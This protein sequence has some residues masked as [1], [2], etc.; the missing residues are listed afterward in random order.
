MSTG[1][2][3]SDKDVLAGFDFVFALHN[4]STGPLS[5]TA[6]A[7][8]LAATGAV[9]DALAGTASQAD[10]TALDARVAANES[11]VSGNGIDRDPV[12]A[13]AGS[14]ITLSGSQTVDGVTLSNGDR[15]GAG[16]QTAPEEI[17][18]YIYN[19]SGPWM[20]ASDMDASS[21][22]NLSTVFVSG[23]TTYGGH[24]YRF[25]V[26]D[27]DTFA[28][29]TDAITATQVG[30]AGALGDQLAL[31]A[32]ADDPTF[33]G[34][35]DMSGAD[36]V[37]V[38]DGAV[39]GHAVNKGQLDA[40]VENI[41]AL[42]KLTTT[43][44]RAAGEVAASSS[45]SAATVVL[46]APVPVDGQ[47]TTIRLDS[48]ASGTFSIR[49]FDRDG[50]DFTQS[51]SDTDVSI[52]GGGTNTITLETPISVTAGQYLGGYF[53]ATGVL[54]FDNGANDNPYFLA[55]GDQTSFTDSLA[56]N[57]LELGFD[58]Q[59][60]VL[61]V[62]N[63]Q[64]VQSGASVQDAVAETRDVVIGFP[65]TLVE[66]VNTN[67]YWRVFD[68]P[69]PADG[70]VTELEWY[71]TQGYLIAG[72]WER[73]GDTW[74]KVSSQNVYGTGTGVVSADLA[75]PIRKGQYLGLL[76]SD[77]GQA[78]RRLA[79]QTTVGTVVFSADTSGDLS[80]FA[81]TDPNLAEHIQARFTLKVRDLARAV[82][83]DN[84]ARIIVFGDSYT[85]SDYTLPGKAWISI[86]SEQ[87]DFMWENHSTSGHTMSNRLSNIGSST[88]GDIP[89]LAHAEVTYLMSYIGENDDNSLS[90]AAFTEDME[91]FCQAARGIGAV[92]LLV[93]QHTD[94]YGG[95]AVAIFKDLADRYGG[96]YGS[97]RGN[98]YEADVDANREA[99]FQSGGHYGTRKAHVISD[100][101]TRIVNSLPRPQQALKVFRPRS[102]VTVST[103]ADLAFVNR[104]A[105]R[106]LW[107]EIKPGQSGLKAV[108]YAEYDEVD[109]ITPGTDSEITPSEYMS[110]IDGAGVSC[111]DYALIEVL[112][113]S[114]R[115]EASW[116]EMGDVDA[117]LYFYDGQA[118]AWVEI[119]SDG[120][121]AWLLPRYVMRRGLMGDRLPLLIEKSGSF[122]LTD[123]VFRWIGDAVSVTHAPRLSLARPSGSELLA[124]TL[125]GTALELADW[126]VT[127]T[128]TAEGSP[129]EAP[130]G[131]TSYCTVTDA[132][133]IA[134]TVTVPDSGLEREVEIRVRGRFL[135]AIFDSS[136]DTFPDDS[137]ITLDSYDERDLVITATV[138]SN[139]I[140][141]TRPVGLSWRD[142]RVRIPV[143]AG[144]S[145]LTVEI[146]TAGASI[147][148]AEVSV[149][150]VS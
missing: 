77:S 119:E 51:G 22:I 2:R 124:Q 91:E 121:G 105:R 63:M 31:K 38:P 149:R 27:P 62:A 125:C 117:A 133:T 86:A 106:A 35:V 115:I 140:P 70:I 100:E 111:E 138:N 8:A 34:D 10:L 23:G 88:Y 57:T 56:S 116:F 72:I 75:I 128:V 9:A 120:S 146:A 98:A 26:A 144:H 87:T 137:D 108:K 67:Q 21:E 48:N 145:S 90:I 55:A 61:T 78:L 71:R 134:Q 18:V 28:L 99:G 45:L 50:D 142:V 110:L 79:S 66:G 102:E 147:Q 60:D 89:P 129:V 84:S 103:V 114:P 85:Q 131:A 4:G 52:T 141:I 107:S 32:D 95:A 150:T 132:N 135:P 39:S 6:L 47:I 42:P 24:S 36:S 46:D 101:M 58:I 64:A 97:V 17:G 15:V 109:G 49:V 54:T 130:R 73:D 1:I 104:A 53:S 122:T 19:D 13:W 68:Q 16:A 82:T 74:T 81:D 148:I 93:Q 12:V 139:A 94:T 127:G 33:T 25:S 40:A 41:D 14:D 5:S 112:L 29:D 76:P 43:L 123:P 11:A 59:S 65:G 37:A 143:G 3:I 96:V 44:G 118:A 30:D 7:T 136:T 126:T 80:S 92:P 83:P 20:R 69:A 113:P